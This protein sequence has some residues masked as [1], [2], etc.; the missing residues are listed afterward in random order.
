MTIFQSGS[1]G[2]MFAAAAIPDYTTSTFDFRTDYTEDELARLT[3]Q[4]KLDSRRRGP[5][6]QQH[7]VDDGEERGVEADAERE[8][9]DGGSGEGRLME[10]LPNAEP[11]IAAEIQQHR[12]VPPKK[13]RSPP[14]ARSPYS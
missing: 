6:A 7:G 8:R 12:P 4:Q 11:H 5:R 9:E 10:Q 1:L 13:G 3:F 14:P 2:K